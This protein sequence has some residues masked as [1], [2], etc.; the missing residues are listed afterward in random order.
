MKRTQSAAILA[1]L[2]NGDR[3]TPQ[4]ALIR[5]GCFRLGA[6]IY[7]LRQ[8]GYDIESRLVR[9]GDSRVAEYSMKGARV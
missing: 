8:D 1:A 2:R 7:D 6:R 3:L 9:Y 4:G 5:F